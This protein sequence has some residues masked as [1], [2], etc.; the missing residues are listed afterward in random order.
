MPMRLFNAPA[1]RKTISVLL[2]TSSWL[3]NSF[4]CLPSLA[5]LAAFDCRDARSASDNAATDNILTAS[6]PSAGREKEP[7]KRMTGSN[8]RFASA[9]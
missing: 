5:S 9:E 2:A 7:V 3:C 8:L 6:I 4:R 1:D